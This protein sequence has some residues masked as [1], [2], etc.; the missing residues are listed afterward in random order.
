MGIVSTVG[1]TAAVESTAAV[2]VIVVVA[3]GWDGGATVAAAGVSAITGLALPAL[4][5]GRLA[6]G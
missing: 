5:A 4:A 1:V 3:V 2:A 6:D